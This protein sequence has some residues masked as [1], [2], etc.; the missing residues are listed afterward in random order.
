MTFTEKDKKTLQVGVFIAILLGAGIFYYHITIIKPR[1]NAN[2]SK[3][4]ELK[5]ET[6]QLKEDYRTMLAL[7]D[8]E[9]LIKAMEKSV[10]DAARRLPSRPDAP[11]FL[12]ELIEILRMTGVKNQTITPQNYDEHTLYTAIP[13]EIECHSRYH[14]FGQFLNLIEENPNRFMRVNSFHARNDQ[15]RPSIHPVSLRISTFMFNPQ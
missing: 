8:Q 7:K 9:D 5:E 3:A 6:K 1:I 14:E 2:N 12:N 13:Y 11:G 4:E 10:R 15:K